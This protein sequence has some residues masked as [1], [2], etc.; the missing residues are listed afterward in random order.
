MAEPTIALVGNPNT[1]KTTLFNALTGLRHHVANYPGVT[2]EVHTGSAEA[3]NAT[4]IDVPGCY[5]LAPRSLDELLAVELLLGLRNGTP[6]PDAVVCVVDASN[7]E[8][9]LYLASQVVELGIPTVLALN[10]TDVAERRGISVDSAKLSEALG[11]P[12]VPIIARDE[13]GLDQLVQT[14]KASIGSAP[15]TKRPE[16]PAAVRAEVANLS[17]KLASPPAAY[18]LER[19]LF[20]SGGQIEKTLTAKHGADFLTWAEESRGRLKEAGVSV[21][22][23]EAK[24]RYGWIADVLSGAITR[25]TVRKQTWSDRLDA[26][27][28]HRF[29]GVVA[30]VVVMTAFFA[31]IFFGAKKIQDP[32]G[33]LLDSA[34]DAIASPFYKEDAPDAPIYSLLRH[35]ALA[36]V[37]AVLVFL[38]Q[39]ALLFGFLAVLE[40]CGYM[41]RAAFLMDRLLSK[42]GLSGKSFIP[43]LS[44]FACAVPGVMATRTIEDP[45]DRLITMLVAPLMSCSARLPVYILLVS[46]FVPGAMWQTIT[47]IGLYFLGLIAAPLVAWTLKKTVLKG[48]P[49]MFLLELP[50][51]K[52]PRLDAVLHRMWDRSWAFVRRAST[53]I[54]AT[55]IVLWAL[56]YYPRPP[57]IESSLDSLKRRAE[58]LKFVPER[59]EEAEATLKEFQKEKAK[60]YQEQSYLARFGKTIE[61]LVAPLGWDWKIGTAAIA[62]FPAREVV[63]AALGTI[64]S[65]GDVDTDEGGEELVET[66][67]AQKRPDGTPVFN[68]AVAGSLLVFFALCCQC[69]STLAVIR[70]ESGTWR[71]PIFTFV[72][73]TVLAYVGAFLTYRVI[74]HFSG[75]A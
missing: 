65:V 72:Y 20:D 73:M 64:Y 62:S 26:V 71:W 34:A 9:N 27:L 5:S 61:P 46:A 41:A 25:P 56:A 2:V 8:R 51:Y 70:R 60:R 12:V 49:S 31:V 23:L 15:P 14:V 44:S 32:F 55:S 63:V 58:R 47:M 57:E 7:L 22:G 40:D 67:K 69:V 38:P 28:L 59:Q 16:F 18:L 45:R 21:G 1:G 37:T 68:L 75:G 53:F 29:W 4:I 30:F 54:L 19:V 48:E 24:T 10:M 3:M 6:R 17:A 11:V 74:L 52:R 50:S 33:D 42:C 36:G 13:V 35:G 66:M 39:I 43:M